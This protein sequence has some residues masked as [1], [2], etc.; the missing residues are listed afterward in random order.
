MKSLFIVTADETITNGSGDIFE[1]FR[2]F[3]RA[4]AMKESAYQWA[5]TS[6]YD[7]RRSQVGVS[8]YYIP[9]DAGLDYD[10]C[11]LDIQEYWSEV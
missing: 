8:E 6:E 4:E 5:H 2:T 10:I 3:D 7:R 9:D 11:G 1:L